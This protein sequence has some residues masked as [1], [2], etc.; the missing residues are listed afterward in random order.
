MSLPASV[1]PSAYLAGKA[2]INAASGNDE[3]LKEL[4]KSWE[5]TG[6]LP[7]LLQGDLSGAASNL[8]D[9]PRS[10]TR[11]NSQAQGMSSDGVWA[12]SPARCPV[13]TSVS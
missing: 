12:P 1:L 11:W 13:V 2:G 5:E 10:T 7:K 3:E 4:L 9:H 8:K 6:V